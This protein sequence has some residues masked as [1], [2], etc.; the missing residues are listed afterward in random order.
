MASELTVRPSADNRKKLIQRGGAS[1]YRCYQCATCSSVC[2]L[3]PDN[4]PFPRRQMQL[5]QWGLGEQLVADPA[6]WLCHQCNDC[7]TRCPRDAK[8]GD[9]M[10]VL[11]GLAVEQLATPSFM[12]KLVGN[13]RST[14]P[15][16]IGIPIVFWIALLGAVHGLTIPEAPLVYHD[17]V[18]HYLIYA[19]YLSTTAGV[20]FAMISGGMRF[21]KLLTAA[22]P[23]RKEAGPPLKLIGQVLYDIMAHKRFQTCGT[24]RPRR[25]GH[26]SLFWGFVGAAGVSG[27]IVVLMYG[28][29]TE[30][31]LPQAHWVKVLGNVAAVLLV[32][33]GLMLLANR[34]NDS[35]ST[36]AAHA[37]DSFLLGVVL[38]VVFSGV[39][40]ELGRLF[41]DPQLACGIYIIHLGSVLCLFATA[42]YSKLAH[43]LYRT[44]A[45][46]H[47]RMTTPML[48]AASKAD[49]ADA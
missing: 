22:T 34:F 15:L 48:P 4:A 13:V 36:G 19:V 21:W 10:Q 25:W 46:V 33:G 24:A 18:P 47:E 49:K 23:V 44:L 11:R 37:F 45:M 31:P 7:S 1:A 28:F 6:L 2:E 43:L 30:L 9:V 41:F 5:A 39:F 12:G 42:P 8:P 32:V 26:F 14:W 35:S 27:I 17:F 40:T 38:L 3:A 20:L 29:G 16:L